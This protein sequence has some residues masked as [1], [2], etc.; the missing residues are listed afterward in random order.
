MHSWMCADQPGQQAGET[1]CQLREEQRGAEAGVERQAQ[2]GKGGKAD[3][4]TVAA[5]GLCN[6][7][8]IQ[9]YV[10]QNN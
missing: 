7:N 3:R 4:V 10:S 5:K 6:Q 2:Q 8:R 9:L 1:R